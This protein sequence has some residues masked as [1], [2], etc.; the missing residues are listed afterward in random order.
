MSEEPDLLAELR[1]TIAERNNAY[2]VLAAIRAASK[3]PPAILAPLL[4]RLGTAARLLTLAQHGPHAAAWG[5]V[6]H[7]LREIEAALTM[8]RD[9]GLQWDSPLRSSPVKPHA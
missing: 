5:N 1:A 9:T 3:H 7:A 4:D 8:V 6:A 2:R